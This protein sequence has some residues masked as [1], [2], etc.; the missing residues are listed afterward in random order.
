MSFI[1]LSLL[2]ENHI[3]SQITIGH[4]KNLWGYERAPWDIGG[5][6]WEFFWWVVSE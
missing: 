4:V 3:K 5:E 1:K 6:K 2:L